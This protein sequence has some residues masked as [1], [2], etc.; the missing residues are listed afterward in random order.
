MNKRLIRGRI[1]TIKNNY[2]LA[3]AGIDLM[4]LSDAR[5]RLDEVFSSLKAHPETKFFRYMVAI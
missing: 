4:A 5:V 1:Q 3:Q 2:A